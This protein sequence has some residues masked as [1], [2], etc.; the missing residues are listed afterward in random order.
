MYDIGLIVAAVLLTWGATGL[1]V[2]ALSD[3]RHYVPPNE[4]SMHAVP[5]PAGGGI[6]IVTAIALLWPLWG[7]PLSFSHRAVLVMA[8]VLA[9]VSWIDDVRHLRPA[10]RFAFHAAA[11]AIALVLVPATLRL[12]PDLPIVV[13]RLAIAI[14]WLWFVNLT[15]FMD[16][17][18]GLAASEA[19][20]VGLGYAGV[21]TI[22]GI[23]KG[24]EPLALII[25]GA[26]AGYLVWNWHPA[27]IFM[28]DVGSIPLGFL[29]GWLMLDLALHRQIAAALILPMYFA[30]DATITLMRRIAKGE[31]PWQPHRSHFYQ[32]AVQGGAKQDAVVLRVTV[33]NTILIL[34]A[35]LSVHVPVPAVAAAAVVTTLLLVN[36]SISARGTARAA[37]GKADKSRR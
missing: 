11:V 3:R 10:A 17:I 36:L 9:L 33:A 16:G 28:G 19:I 30:A 6:A 35:I 29:I 14:A 22:A 24:L 7:W 37:K 26:S 15:N 23:D 31:K 18:D 12:V 5:T 1:T 8:V 34:L 4:R 25:A 21:T 27:R 13:E 2:N 32:R 20:A